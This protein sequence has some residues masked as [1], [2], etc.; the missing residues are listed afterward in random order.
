MDHAGE[1]YEENAKNIHWVTSTVE[2]KNTAA[3]GE[4]SVGLMVVVQT[5]N[6][7]FPLRPVLLESSLVSF[8]KYFSGMVHCILPRF[9][10]IGLLVIF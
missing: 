8:L 7:L 1:I 2:F 6:A 3:T 4:C 9:G 5:P 10:H